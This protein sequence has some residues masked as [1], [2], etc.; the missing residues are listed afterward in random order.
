MH[1]F[2]IYGGCSRETS[3]SEDQLE[4]GRMTARRIADRSDTG[5]ARAHVAA[6]ALFRVR[7][8]LEP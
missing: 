3:P 7:V 4:D 6:V 5:T 8:V 1:I 2:M